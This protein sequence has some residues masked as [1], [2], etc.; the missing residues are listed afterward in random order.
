MQFPQGFNFLPIAVLALL[1]SVPSAMA[2]SSELAAAEKRAAEC[3]K[4]K[5]GEQYHERFFKV[6]ESTLNQ[7]MQGCLERTPDTKDLQHPAEFVFIIGGDGRLKKL[8]YSTDIPFGQCVGPKLLSVKSLPRPPA[9]NWYVLVGLGNTYHRISGQ[10]ILDEPR[11]THGLSEKAALDE[12]LAPSVAKARRTYPSAKKR[13]IAGLPPG[14]RF[15]V[16]VS[17]HDEGGRSERCFV[18]VEKIGNG[19]ITGT[20]DKVD[21]LQSYKTGQRITFPESE[22]FNWLILRP[23]GTEEGNYVGKSLDRYKSN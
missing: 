13:F 20:I 7:A 6:M 1:P 4:T 15:S 12:S 22:V 21:I 23:D 9:D 19:K 3:E 10:P 18:H 16:Q 17:L 8:I 5:E 11:K 14:H 2:K